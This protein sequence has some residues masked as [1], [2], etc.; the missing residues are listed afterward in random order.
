MKSKIPHSLAFASGAMIIYK[1]GYP[2]PE[3]SPDIS[4]FV[5]KLETWL[6]MSGIP[7]ESR[8][9]PNQAMPHEKLPVADIDGELVP[10]SSLIIQRLLQLYPQAISDKHLSETERA[11]ACALT[12][13]IEQHLYFA[14]L[15]NRYSVQ[16]NFN[17]YKPLLLDYAMRS[18][19][20]WQKPLLS[21]LSPLIFPVVQRKYRQMAWQQGTG[22]HK[23]EDIHATGIEGWKSIKTILGAKPFLMG[24]QPC[25][26][27]MSAF[28]FLHAEIRHPFAGRMHDYVMSEPALV[29]YHDRIWNRYW[30]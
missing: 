11:Q 17:A 28:G 8:T 18:V 25:L 26:V 14:L 21:I 23:I 5:V 15:H 19:P 16:S 10:D 6:R 7:Y 27:D 30:K 22:R 20:A 29:D 12:A 9:G 1:F 13:L 24:G 3:V 4:P 2:A